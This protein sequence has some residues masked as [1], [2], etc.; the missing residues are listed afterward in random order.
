M[1]TSAAAQFYVV[2]GLPFARFCL[3]LHVGFLCISGL[4][5]F[6]FPFALQQTIYDN[7]D[8]ERVSLPATSLYGFQG[9][10]SAVGG[11]SGPSSARAAA[12]SSG[13][14]EA[15]PFVA[16]KAPGGQ[17][18]DGAREGAS[19]A[20]RP[21]APP[22]RPPARRPRLR[23]GAAGA[24]PGRALRR[25]ASR[26]SQLSPP[27]PLPHMMP[28]KRR[29]RRQTEHPQAAGPCFSFRLSQRPCPP[30]SSPPLR[31]AQ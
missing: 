14:R 8:G 28:I 27:R 6:S 17:P 18:S 10:G 29:E 2:A 25:D 23:C 22:S 24:T 20:P 3:W 12:E 21:P 30:P 26:L 11:L 5:Q 16:K 15:E 9:K 31:N 7:E 1:N 4:E 13:A 19:P